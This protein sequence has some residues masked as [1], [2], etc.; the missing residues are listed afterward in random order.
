[1]YYGHFSTKLERLLRNFKEQCT[2]QK[3]R[4]RQS[5][6]EKNQ[7]EPSLYEYQ[8]LLD[9]VTTTS[10][11]NLSLEIRH[12]ALRKKYL[13]ASSLIKKE[14]DLFEKFD[15]ERVDLERKLRNS[16]NNILCI[17]GSELEGMSKD[18][19]FL[20]NLGGTS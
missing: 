5:R 2:L 10:E 17:V 16:V 1:M 7:K 14:S 19:L 18:L 11:T 12:H 20:F 8:F 3:L 15:V 9:S 6:S 13:E 4:L